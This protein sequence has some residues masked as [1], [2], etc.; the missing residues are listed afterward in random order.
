MPSNGPRISA[1]TRVVLALLVAGL[2]GGPVLLML[3]RAYA[4]VVGGAGSPE[5]CFSW[6]ELSG[7]D[8]D[9][10]P[11]VTKT[12]VGVGVLVVA[13]LLA[14]WGL[15]TWA[16]R[17]IAT[18]RATVDAMGPQ[19]LGQ[20]TGFTSRREPVGRLGESLDAML[21]RIAAGY[22]GQRRFASN[23]S[24]EL[25]TPLAV[26][27]TLIE[28]S[29]DQPL[30]PAASQLLAR[31]L[32]ATNE[33]NEQL[34]EGLLVLAETDRGLA[35]REPVPVDEV[36][37]EVLA[38]HEPMAAEAGVTLKAELGALTVEGERVLLERL[39]TNL[40]QNAI[41]YNEPGGWVLIRSTANA[42]VVSNT[43]PVV[44]AEAVPGLF[45]P[46]RRLATERTGQRSGSGLGLTIVRSIA[47]AHGATSTARAGEDGGLVVTLTFP[48]G[49]L[50]SPQP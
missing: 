44:P 40:V 7:Y 42:L 35:G 9:L 48:A 37:A 31:Q 11:N 18:M 17:P 25:R 5:T 27:R 41:K 28:V 22:E 46:F 14:W 23:A 19:N 6:S 8:C 45:E 24:H 36:A 38:N 21:D 13:T 20:R 49:R 50:V 30:T 26:Q 16:L 47:T 43:G 39:L 12:L 15:A 4:R 34:I 1:R 29:M 2:L 10:E 33:R 3:Y 32:L